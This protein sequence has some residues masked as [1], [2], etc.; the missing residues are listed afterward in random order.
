[1]SLLLSL[2]DA[3]TWAMIGTLAV[4]ALVFVW[5][6][7]AAGENR[8]IAK[9]NK[10]K[11]EAVKDKKAKDDEINSLSPADL[12]KRFDRWMRDK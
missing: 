10:A 12:D 7:F 4:G 9:D 11:L 5:R 3:K 6:I 1:M 8:Q 2:F